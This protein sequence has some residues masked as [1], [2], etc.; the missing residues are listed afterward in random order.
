[1]PGGATF[2]TSQ[3]VMTGSNSQSPSGFSPSCSGGFFG[4]LG[5]CQLQVTTNQPGTY[6]FNWSYATSDTAGAGADTFGVIVDS[7]RIP[8]T[9][10]AG[11]NS[12]SGSESFA[13][14]S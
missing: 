3:L 10:L 14:A 1:M 7:T 13:A 8:L 6:S 4:T 2:S 9:E 5:P 11:G 12:Q